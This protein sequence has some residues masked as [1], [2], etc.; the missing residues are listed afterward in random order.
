M[1]TTS[2]EPVASIDQYKSFARILAGTVPAGSYDTIPTFVVGS[3]QP[4][5]R[6]LLLHIIAILF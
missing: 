3:Q 1:L 4:V 5:I 6:W 2:A